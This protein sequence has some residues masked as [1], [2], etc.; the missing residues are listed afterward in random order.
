MAE[1]AIEEIALKTAGVAAG[2]FL[3]GRSRADQE[4]KI[5]L[6]A[7]RSALPSFLSDHRFEQTHFQFLSLLIR[8]NLGRGGDT[9]PI[10]ARAP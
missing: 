3:L 8:I 5:K 1:L 9:Y 4:G 6:F 7:E 10:L 2:L